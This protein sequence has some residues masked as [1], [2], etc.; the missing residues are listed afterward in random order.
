[1]PDSDWQAACEDI[2]REFRAGRYREG[3]V[4]GVEDVGKI[5]GR[6][7]PQLPGQRDED[8]LPN[9]PRLL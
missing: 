3:A 7:F 1:V 9:R 5:I 8:E 2:R 6:H 4:V